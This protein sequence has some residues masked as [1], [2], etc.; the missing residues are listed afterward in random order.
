[1]GERFR[2]NYFVILRILILAILE[3]YLI[4]SRPL[5]TGASVE[6]LLLLALFTGVIAG[7][8]LINGGYRFLLFILAI[9]LYIM[10]LYRVGRPFVILGVFLYYEIMTGI[11]ARK[12]LYFFPLCVIFIQDESSTAIYL[13]LTLGIR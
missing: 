9:G 7:K 10:I 12:F 6:M 11:K 3:L 1:M 5:L 4:F 13:M 8:E 2:E